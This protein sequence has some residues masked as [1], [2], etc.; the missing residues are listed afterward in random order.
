MNNLEEIYSIDDVAEIETTE[1][2]ITDDLKAD[3]AIKIIKQEEAQSI[4]LVE[5]INQEIEILK[6]K[7]DKLKESANCGFLK[8]KLADYFDTLD[9]VKVDKTQISYK[10]P[11]G[12]L[13][14]K[15]P[16]VEYVKDE[17]KILNYLTANDRFE[18]IKTNPKVDWGNLKKLGD[19]EL[20]K[21]D[22]ITIQQ[23]P[24]SFNVK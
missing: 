9:G 20:T 24:A 16:S 15:R 10:L 6:A 2:T 3:W 12:S 14:L 8:G 21:I 19:D 23:K 4:R 13:V 7:A 1:F 11:S 18:F 5:T 22:G 17:E